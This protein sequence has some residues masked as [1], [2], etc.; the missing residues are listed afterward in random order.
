MGPDTSRALGAGAALGA[1][2]AVVTAVPSKWYGAPT[3]DA[4]VFDPGTFSPLWVQRTLVP[5][6]SLLAVMLLAGG[7]AGLVLRDRAVAGR[8]RRWGGASA[9]V[10]LGLG[11]VTMATFAA[12]EGS[13]STD[14]L[15]SLLVLVGLLVGLVGVP[16]ALAGLVAAGVGYARTERP[17]VGYA[18]VGGPAIATVVALAG[19]AGALPTVVGFL[20]V[21]VPLAA[22][23]AVVGWELWIHPEPLDTAEPIDAED[24]DGLDPGEDGS[25]T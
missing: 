8:A 4:Y 15:D 16:L 25:G 18:L 21:S 3:T 1:V 5:V 17:P 10:G 13:A 2:L 6:A 7:V 20:P 24:D 12:A 22:A 9:A 23:F 14:G 11:A 19:L